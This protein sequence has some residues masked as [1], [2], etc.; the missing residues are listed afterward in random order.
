MD[1]FTTSMPY[2][3]KLK[4]HNSC[5]IKYTKGHETRGSTGINLSVIVFAVIAFMFGV[6]LVPIIIGYIIFSI[7]LKKSNPAPSNFEIE[8]NRRTNEISV[9]KSDQANPNVTVYPL[10]QLKGFGFNDTSRRAKSKKAALVN[11]FFKLEPSKGIIRDVPIQKHDHPV[12]ISNAVDIIE[13]IEDWL[14]RTEDIPVIEE[15]QPLDE[16]AQ[17]DIIRDFRDMD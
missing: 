6:E 4:S 13:E 5:L 9:R 3:I 11:L 8:L 7:F 14:G 2:D 16:P 12:P 17:E 10:N 15:V 1:N